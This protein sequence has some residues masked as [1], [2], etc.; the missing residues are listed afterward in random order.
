MGGQDALGCKSLSELEP[1]DGRPEGT[2]GFPC[3]GILQLQGASGP[4]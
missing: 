3:A 4:R 1:G 2:M